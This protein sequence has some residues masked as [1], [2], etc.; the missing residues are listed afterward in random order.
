M[1]TTKKMTETFRENPQQS[2]IETCSNPRDLWLSQFLRCFILP[3]SS[4][5]SFW[6][7]AWC[8]PL[9]WWNWT[10]N[11]APSHF[12]T[13]LT[14]ICSYSLCICSKQSANPEKNLSE[15]WS[16]WGVCVKWGVGIIERG[17][18]AAI[19]SLRALNQSANGQKNCKFVLLMSWLQCTMQLSF[20]KN[21]N[22]G[23]YMK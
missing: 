22:W 3:Y 18:H 7:Y 15:S 2:Y 12:D 11:W 21:G 20:S 19:Y 5:H 9:F 8:T 13:L 4:S 10:K 1:T 17:G 16:K 14:L 6:Q 23:G